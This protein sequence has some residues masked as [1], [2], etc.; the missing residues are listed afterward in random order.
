MISAFFSK[1]Q[2][3]ILTICILILLSLYIFQSCE[4]R[5][6]KQTMGQME[7]E[8]Q[9]KEAIIQ[10]E[11]Q[12]LITRM[13]DIDA[14]YLVLIGRENE[15]Y[16]TRIKEIDDTTEKC[17]SAISEDSAELERMLGTYGISVLRAENN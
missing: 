11:Y 1:F 5:R 15:K 7:K 13:N 9:K 4:T 2:T 3:V 10:K 6:V 17:V 12:T 8:A 16:E 14:K